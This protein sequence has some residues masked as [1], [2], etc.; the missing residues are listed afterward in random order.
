MERASIST[1]GHEE[2]E[3]QDTGTDLLSDPKR[4]DVEHV[5]LMAT[6]VYLHV[7]WIFL[8][9]SLPLT[10][11]DAAGCYCRGP[12]PDT[13]DSERRRGGPKAETQ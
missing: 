7:L 12:V 9:F 4:K 11:S 8:F 2:E 1:F 5:H 6:S 3:E 10:L 13:E